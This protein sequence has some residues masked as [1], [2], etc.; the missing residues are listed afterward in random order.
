M[1]TMQEHIDN[2]M[3]MIK[4][5]P[6]A[7]SGVELSVKL[8]ALKDD[9]DIES[10]LVT[11]E[12]IM[13]AHKVEK[14]R[15]LHYLAPQLAGKA[16]LALAA[17]AIT[18]EKRLWL[19]EKKPR[20]CVAAGELVDEFEQT[21]RRVAEGKSPSEYP[22]SVKKAVHTAIRVV[23]LKKNVEERGKMW[24]ADHQD[25]ACSGVTSVGR[26]DINQRIV[27]KEGE[28]CLTGRWNIVADRESGRGLHHITRETAKECL[29]DFL[30]SVKAAVDEL[31]SYDM[32]HLD[33][34]LPNICLRNTPEEHLDNLQVF[35]MAFWILLSPD[36]VD[37]HQMHKIKFSQQYKDILN[38]IQFTNLE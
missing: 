5:Q 6:V 15:W 32:A 28:Q 23:V 8:V 31:H 38:F 34:R 3:S 16:Q 29:I 30:Q 12:R 9:D 7:K 26:L 19:V 33:I 4:A 18:E 25:R 13:A 2:L 37:Y 27:R 10:Y 35:W 14:E 20:S 22:T 17:L 36:E 11:F 21:R 24:V 1:E